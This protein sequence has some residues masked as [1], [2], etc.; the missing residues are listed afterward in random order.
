MKYDF[1]LS[2]FQLHIYRELPGTFGKCLLIS[3][4]SQA[5]I[6]HG[7]I[8]NI[9]NGTQEVKIFCC[10]ENF[11]YCEAITAWFTVEK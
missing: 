7:I 5:F 2:L 3:T 4:S 10:V 1:L 11:G 9:H 8:Y 6:V